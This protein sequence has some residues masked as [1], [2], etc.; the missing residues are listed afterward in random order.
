[1][2]LRDAIGDLL[3]DVTIDIVDAVEPTESPMDTP[4][5]E[6]LGRVATGYYADSHLIPML[7]VGGTDNRWMRPTGAVGYGFGLFS[8][9]LSLEDLATMGHGDNERIDVESM[10]M[11]TAMWESLARD[12]LG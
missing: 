12:F 11:I 3:P 7:M 9:K 10:H 1:M 4:L 8:R 2:M 6:S 5:W